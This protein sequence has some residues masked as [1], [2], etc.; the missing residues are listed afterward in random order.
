M[1][2]PPRGPYLSCTFKCAPYTIQINSFTCRAS[3]ATKS[4]YALRSFML[5]CV[6]HLAAFC[7]F[8]SILPPSLPRTISSDL[9]SLLELDSPFLADPPSLAHSTGQHSL[10]DAYHSREKTRF[11]F[12]MA[13]VVVCGAVR[14]LSNIRTM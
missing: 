1:I 3:S 7:A 13:R 10:K 6:C 4:P 2:Q 5:L 8:S 12:N 14:V 9:P 11:V